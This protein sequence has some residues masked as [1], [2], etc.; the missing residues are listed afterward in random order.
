MECRVWLGITFK[1]RNKSYGFLNMMYSC[2]IE[3]CL[4]KVFMKTLGAKAAN[5]LLCVPIKSS[6]YNLLLQFQN[7]VKL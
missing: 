3:K 1:N 7:V 2:I 5:K 4:L 6:K